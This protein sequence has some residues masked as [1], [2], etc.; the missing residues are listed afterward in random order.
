M[1]E[2]FSNDL[3]IAIDEIINDAKWQK[4]GQPLDLSKDSSFLLYPDLKRAGDE[5]DE[6]L[7]QIDNIAVF[8]LADDEFY[9][10]DCACPHEGNRRCLIFEKHDSFRYDKLFEYLKYVFNP[11]K[12][13]CS[14]RV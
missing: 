9:A 4:I 6:G 13:L 8:C 14:W 11:L 2:G 3:I 12:L 5:G 7:V 1:E 10:I